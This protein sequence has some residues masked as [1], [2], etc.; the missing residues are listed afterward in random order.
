MPAAPAAL[1]TILFLYF[2]GE[3]TGMHTSCLRAIV[4]F[5]FQA[6][7]KA[8]GRTYDLLTALGCRRRAS[9]WPAS[10]LWIFHSGFLFSFAAVLAMGT[11]GRSFP[12]FSSSFLRSDLYDSRTAHVLLYLSALFHC[13]ERDRDRIGSFFDGRR[14]GLSLRFCYGRC[15]SAD[16]ST[17]RTVSY[18]F[19][20]SVGQISC[21]HTV[22]V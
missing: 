20:T 15:L 21:F 12:G 17:C 2:Y 3:M 5:G 6:A 11:V 18:R 16:L 4:M 1:I 19:G 22:A 13:A 7:A 9:P 14:A 8:I 10:P